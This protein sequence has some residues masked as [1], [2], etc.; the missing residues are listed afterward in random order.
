MKPLLNINHRIWGSE[1]FI[2]IQATLQYKAHCVR[3]RIVSA[4][5]ILFWKWKMWKFSFS[6]CIMAIFYFIT[7]IA[8]GG[9]LF[10]EIRYL[11][12][13]LSKC[14]S[15]CVSKCVSKCLSKYL[16]K[17]LLKYRISANSFCR[18]YS[19][20]N[21]TLCTVT[22]GYSTYRCGN[23]SREETIQGR[24]LFAEIRYINA[25]PVST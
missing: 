21:L 6:F 15:K 4:E 16:S 23:Y 11:S 10:A 9:K 19:F 5:T 14:P 25:D 24:K 7:W 17:Y 2:V 8:A 13:Y 3:W 1:N 22:F 12:K 20:L 18:N